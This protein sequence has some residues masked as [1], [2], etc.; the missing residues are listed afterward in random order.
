[1]A[2]FLGHNSSKIF[3]G[4]HLKQIMAFIDVL[5]SVDHTTID[6][7]ERRFKERGQDFGVTLSFLTEIGIIS[8]HDEALLLEPST[9]EVFIGSDKEA[10]SHELINSIFGSTNSYRDSVVEYLQ[11]YSVIDGRRSEER[12]VGKECRSRWSPYH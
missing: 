1:M 5:Q 8:V 4:L 7:V 12:R 9:S 3:D 10:T 2:D 11:D 6:Y